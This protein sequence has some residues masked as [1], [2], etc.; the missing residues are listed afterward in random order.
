MR[1]MQQGLRQFFAIVAQI[2]RRVK[3]E[4]AVAAPPHHRLGKGIAQR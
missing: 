4:I 3:A 1:S 2:E